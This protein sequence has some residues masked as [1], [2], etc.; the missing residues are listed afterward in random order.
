M[1]KFQSPGP[2]RDC[3]NYEKLFTT[4]TEKKKILH[5]INSRR[6]KISSGEI[7]SLPSAENMLKLEW[8]DELEVIAQRWADQCFNNF[9]DVTK[10]CHDLENSSVGQTIGTIY[11]D[12]PG[13]TA[14]SIV[15]L[16]YMEL[17]N[18]NASYLERYS[19]STLTSSE[20]YDDFTQL[21]WAESSR[22]GCGGVIFKEINTESLTVQ[23]K[24]VYRLICNFSPSGNVIGK[25]VYNSGIPCSRCPHGRYCDVEYQFLCS[26]Y[27]HKDETNFTD[28][29]KSTTEYKYSY[30]L[31]NINGFVKTNE[32]QLNKTEAKANLKLNETQNVTTS[33]IVNDND[34]YFDFLSHLFDIS[35]THAINLK[36][37]TLPCK[38]NLAV[39]DFIE[40]LKSKL[41]NDQS[42]KDLL[43]SSTTTLTPDST[44]TDRT[45]AAI[46]NQLYSKKETTTTSQPT[47]DQNI[48]STLLADLV[49]A[50]I[51]RHSG[52]YS[53]TE[54][55]LNLRT[56]IISNVI[57]IKIQAELGEIQS[58]TE[59]SGHYFFPEEEEKPDSNTTEVYDDLENLNISEISLEIDELTKNRETKDFL[60]EILESD[61]MT[62]SGITDRVDLN[63]SNGTI[64]L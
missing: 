62:E 7:R 27:V 61:L 21:I 13:L 53:T 37:T 29:L 20:H 10:W 51:F 39:D 44:F 24:T 43:L 23:K 19:P 28:E 36:P 60:E 12:A 34:T 18:M 32:D 17:L 46:V 16:W 45:V 33:D 49:E 55:N 64:T 1:C 2:A 63:N 47:E 26:S 42:L 50:V 52:I 57:P 56:Q 59:F 58:N 38:D 4:E 25:S 41:K 8:S 14:A 6:N 9:T 5:R 40:L 22:V 3:I 54:E 35:S 31:T 30:E 11:G 15:D 48:N